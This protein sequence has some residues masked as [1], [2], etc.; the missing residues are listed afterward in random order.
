MAEQ[1]LYTRAG[2]LVGDRN[3]REHEFMV[4]V[5]AYDSAKGAAQ[6]GV[7]VLLALTSALL[8]KPLRGGMAIVGGLNLAL[9]WQS[10]SGGVDEGFLTVRASPGWGPCEEV[11]YGLPD[12]R[13]ARLWRRSPV[14][15]FSVP[16]L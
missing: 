7:P 1:N 15:F 10:R 2:E 8:G 14:S 5:R 16:L 4:Q 3:P 11:E 12:G 6:T 13:H 9:L